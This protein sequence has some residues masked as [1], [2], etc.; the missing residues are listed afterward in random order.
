VTEPGSLVVI[1]GSMFAGK[2]EELIRLVKRAS[3]AKK[4]VQVFKSALDDRW[5]STAVSTHSGMQF[6]AVPV[7][8]SQ[9]LRK[10]VKPDTHVIGIEE[11]QFFD[12]EIVPLCLDFVRKGKT[13]I[14]AGLDQ[15]FRGEPFGCMPILLSLAD[16]VVK[17]RAICMQCGKTA[18]HTQ[19]L[20]NGEP[21]FWDDPVIVIGA[22]EKYEA[23]CRKCH[24]VRFRGKSKKPFTK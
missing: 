16:E 4:K 21:A 23:R 17:L 14:A 1:T 19:R 11:V 7:K 20:V 22:S 9:E 6:E 24:K 18:S 13:V 2:S 15:D 3:Y 5:G 10:L 12:N 8:N